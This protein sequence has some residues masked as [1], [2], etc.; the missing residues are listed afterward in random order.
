MQI[1][2]TEGKDNEFTITNVIESGF[3]VAFGLSENQTITTNEKIDILDLAH[4]LRSVGLSGINK[5]GDNP[6]NKNNREKLKTLYDK[7]SIIF[8][9]DENK[10]YNFNGK[11]VNKKIDKENDYI[12]S[13]KTKYK[14]PNSTIE[15]HG[16]FNLC[17]QFSR[18]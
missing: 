11:Q 5:I 7:N 14:K 16:T 13:Y 12:K 15:Q 2:L 1:K 17:Q 9:Q 4:R 10:N 6:I 8:V 18:R 3:V